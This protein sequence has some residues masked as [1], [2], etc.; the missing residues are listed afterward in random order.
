MW[1]YISVLSRR[2]AHN[3]GK[4]QFSIEKSNFLSFIFF[5]LFSGSNPISPSPQAQK[6]KNFLSLFLNIQVWTF[7]ILLLEENTFLQ[8]SIFFLLFDCWWNFSGFK[9]YYKAVPATAATPLF[10]DR[11][12]NILLAVL[13]SYNEVLKSVIYSLYAVGE[14][15]FTYSIWMIF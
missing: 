8:Y 5:L 15:K 11:E 10:L 7:E 3:L 12:K 2:M 4:L 13:M 6:T 1:C 14:C 9:G